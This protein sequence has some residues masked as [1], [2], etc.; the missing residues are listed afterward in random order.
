MTTRELK[1]PTIRKQIEH[2]LKGASSCIICGHKTIEGRFTDYD[3]ELKCVVCGMPYYVEGNK[4]KPK[5]L[6]RVY[7]LE[8]NQVAKVYTPFF[9]NSPILKAFWKETKQKIPL[10]IYTGEPPFTQQEYNNLWI[11]IWNNRERILPSYEEDFFWT[12]IQEIAEET[13][14]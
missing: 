14:E 1:K 10:G 4:I 5:E 8:P 7:A 12:K 3:G 9:A 13:H 6:K 2:L 11:F